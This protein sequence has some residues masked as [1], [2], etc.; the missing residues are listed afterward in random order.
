MSIDYS[1]NKTEELLQD[2]YFVHS[3]YFPTPESAVFW[4]DQLKSGAVDSR[5][6][7]LARFYLES[8]SVKKERMDLTEM[9]DLFKKI[10]QHTVLQNESGR[11]KYLFLY[12]VAVSVAIL[13][14]SSLLFFLNHNSKQP[15]SLLS[16]VELLKNVKGSGNVELVLSD[17]ECIPIEESDASIQYA[18]KGDIKVNAKTLK[19]AVNEKED[20]TEPAYN[21][22]IVPVGKRSNLIFADGTQM[23]VNAG[24]RVVYP[25]E[26]DKEKREIFVDGE[27]FLQVSPDKNRPFHVKTSDMEIA[28]LGTSFNVTA[29]KS[30]SVHSVVLVHGAVHVS[31]RGVSGQKLVPNDMYVKRNNEVQVKQVEV[32]GYVS[33][34]DGAYAF[35]NEQLGFILQR[36]S[37]YY[38]V[39]I[40][41][42]VSVMMLHCSG[43]LDL[44]EDITRV[45]NGL[46]ETAPIC[47]TKAENGDYNFTYNF[48]K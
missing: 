43:K 48:N 41:A 15:D 21:Q 8:V 36:L 31:G 37:R 17:E 2:D 22:L 47:Y 14:V 3:V 27:V 32:S 19:S 42:D 40:Q 38:G 44:K 12:S 35:R 16:A 18:K 7:E 11:R 30:D 25:V 13:V 33:W 45:L 39:R 5:E 46:T 28:V 20:S 10:E 34:K 24:T 9:D 1:K 23:W 29:Y 4:E 6:Y 26:F